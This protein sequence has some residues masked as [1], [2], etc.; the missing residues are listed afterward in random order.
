MMDHLI[1][2]ALVHSELAQ[3]RPKLPRCDDEFYRGGFYRGD[4]A[5][6]LIGSLWPGPKRG[7]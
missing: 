4:G 3:H 5:W 2:W 6:Q 1:V 7:R